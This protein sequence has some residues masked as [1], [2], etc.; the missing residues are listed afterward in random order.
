MPSKIIIIPYRDR[1]EHKT[2]F[3][4]YI[5]NVMPDDD[6][7]IYF[8]TQ[9]DN[10]PFNRGAMKNIGFLAMKNKYPDYR[11]ISFIFNDVDIMPYTKGVFSYDTTK[12]VIKHNYGYFSCLSASFVIK[13]GDFEKINGFPNIWAWGLEDNIIQDRALA[14]KLK[15]DRTSFSP[16]GSRRVLQLFDGINRLMSAK[17]IPVTKF[18]FKDDGLSTL[19]NI[20]YDIESQH[21]NVKNFDSQFEP[22]ATVSTDIRTLQ[23]SRV[24]QFGMSRIL[25]QNVM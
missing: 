10:R 6:Y 25:Q 2:F 21:I 22:E 15:I 14:H 19:K 9:V 11:N 13:G 24:K 4:N 23:S 7:E 12:G 20:A 17:P 8:S 1:M 3:L 16:L 5:K 18:N